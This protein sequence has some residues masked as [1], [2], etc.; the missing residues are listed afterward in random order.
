MA[1]FPSNVKFG[2][3]DMGEKPD[4]VTES[5]PMERGIPKQRRINSDARVELTLTLHFDSKAE[6]AAFETWFYV[7]IK[8]GQDF[9]DFVHPRT[10]ATVQARFKGG[11]LGT[12]TYLQRTLERSQR[13][14]TLE[15]WR[16]TW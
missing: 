16:S 8:A 7:D 12:L 5:A 4:S 14:V 15:F 10:G 11:E 1:T 2:W 13:Q 9:F 3:R 6:A